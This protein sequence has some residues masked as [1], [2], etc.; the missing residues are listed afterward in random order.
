M[1][2][3]SSPS[4][5]RVALIGECM[6]ELQKSADGQIRQGFG[7]DTLN[8][9]AYLSRIGA[10][11]GTRVSYISALGE[12]GFSLAMRAFWSSE[13]IDHSLTRALPGRVPGLYFIELSPDGERSFSYWR[14]EAAARDVFEGDE[15]ETLLG[16]LADF[17]AIY[18]SGI[19]LAVLRE[20]GRARLLARLRELHERG[21]RIIF[22]CNFRPILWKGDGT[23]KPETNALPWY[24]E[25]MAVADLVFISRDEIQVLGLPPDTD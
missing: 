22:D 6:I 14:G 7:G 12:D 17:D 4:P 20:T 21:T 5:W 3:P 10:P 9:A 15:G 1:T 11:F 13:G 19:S 8:T 25:I 24:R 2:T 23:E 16:N 18:C